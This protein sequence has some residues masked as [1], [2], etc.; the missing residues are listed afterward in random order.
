[1]FN[2]LSK[3][4]INKTVKQFALITIV[5]LTF[6]ISGCDSDTDSTEEGIVTEISAETSTKTTAVEI[7]DTDFEATDWTDLTHSK[8]ADPDFDEVFDNSQ[9][10][11]FDFVMTSERWQSMLNDMTGLYGEFGQKSSGQGL[12]VSPLNHRVSGSSALQS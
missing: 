2:H 12:S 5:S 6:V 8:S 7:T 3:N 11:R 9:V 10:K 1:M 4:K